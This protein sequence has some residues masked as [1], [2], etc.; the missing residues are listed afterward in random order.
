[1]NSSGSPLIVTLSQAEYDISSCEDLSRELEPTYTHPNVIVDMAG[2][3][4]VDSTCLGRLARMRS[5]R[6][7]RG[8]HPAHLVVGANI[9]Y[10]FKIVEFDAIWPLYDSLEAALN[11]NN[12]GLEE[13]P[14]S[15]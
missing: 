4:Y 9:R 12:M 15:G 13:K 2:V 11:E 14:L 7:K 8:F 10:L 3:T 1:M 6:N 5:E